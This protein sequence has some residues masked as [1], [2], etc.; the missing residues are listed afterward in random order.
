MAP[1]ER[2]DDIV[3]DYKKKMLTISFV[4]FSVALLLMS[5]FFYFYNSGE[6]DSI[7]WG[8]RSFNINQL[9]ITDENISGPDHTSTESTVRNNPSLSFFGYS[10]ITFSQ[11]LYPYLMTVRALLFLIGFIIIYHIFNKIFRLWE[12]IKEN[13]DEKQRNSLHKKNRIYLLPVFIFMIVAFMKFMKYSHYYRNMKPVFALW[14]CILVPCL[15]MCIYFIFP[16]KKLLYGRISNIVNSLFWWLL[17]L[18]PLIIKQTEKAKGVDISYS[19]AARLARKR[20]WKYIPYL[21]LIALL[22]LILMVETKFDIVWTQD[23]IKL[24]FTHFIY[25]LEGDFVE[26]FQSFFWNAYAKW[27]FIFVYTIIYGLLYYFFVLYFTVWVDDERMLKKIT[28]AFLFTYII[29]MPFYLFFPVNEVWTTHVMYEPYNYGHTIGVLHDALPGSEAYLYTICSINNCFPSL[30]TSFS[31]TIF[32]LLIINDFLWRRYLL[33]VVGLFSISV[34]IATLYLGVH[35]VTDVIAGA[36]L[37]ILVTYLSQHA[38]IN[39]DMAFRFK[40]IFWKGK[41]RYPRREL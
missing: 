41:K 27:W 34:V 1:K 15:A 6:K 21:L 10:A 30:H 23:I 9:N 8:Q 29:A 14:G 20:L 4:L 16:M 31:L 39:M 25:S 5:V 36:L 18:T 3:S 13:A 7:D 40:E 24:D 2:E 33:P 32:F 26:T 19:E 35:W 28:N 17:F 37:A 38:V 11:D 22:M 12:V